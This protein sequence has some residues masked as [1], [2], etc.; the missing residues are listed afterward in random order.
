MMHGA[1]AMR[2]YS[3]Q[4]AKVARQADFWQWQAT[5]SFNFSSLQASVSEWS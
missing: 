1:A 4:P 2:P 3:L 5:E